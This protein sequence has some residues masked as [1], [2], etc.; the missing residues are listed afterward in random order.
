M[1]ITR[2]ADYAIRAIL[3]LAQLPPGTRAST[4]QIAQA[5]QI[6]LTFLAKIISQLSAVGVVR[7]TRGAHGGVVL[8]RRSAEVSLLEI[9]EAIDGPV[10]LSECTQNPNTCTLSDECVVRV[11]WCTVRAELANRLGNTSFEDLVA[12]KQKRETVTVNAEVVL[13]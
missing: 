2:Q 12:A 4:A 6:P 7:A 8:A 3:H 10:T 1:Q 9:V 11:V 13:N 5:Q